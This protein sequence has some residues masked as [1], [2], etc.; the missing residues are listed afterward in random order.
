[1][2][3][4]TPVSYTHLDV[5]KRQVPDISCEE[6]GPLPGNTGDPREYLGLAIG[7]V[8]KHRYR[9]SRSQQRN[10]G[11]RADITGAS[12]HQDVHLQLHRWRDQGLWT[13]KSFLSRP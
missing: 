7:K 2:G 8:V 3:Y 12:G 10:A 4:Q 13:R 11:V 9:M 1:M 6:S 5:Y